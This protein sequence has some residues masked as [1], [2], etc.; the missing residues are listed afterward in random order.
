MLFLFSLLLKRILAS[1]CS[2]EGSSRASSVGLSDGLL[3]PA[4]NHEIYVSIDAPGN[5]LLNSNVT[6]TDSD[7]PLS[8]PQVGETCHLLGGL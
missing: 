4:S 7:P 2:S 6:L 1:A 5:K 3:S 8:A